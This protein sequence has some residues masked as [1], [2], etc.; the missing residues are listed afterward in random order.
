[1]NTTNTT[2][3][4][5]L[6]IVILGA[7]NSGKS[8]LLNAITGQQTSVVSDVE[9]TT[10]DIIY[11]AIELPDIGA[12]LIID[13]PGFD[14][15]SIL[16][17]K[18]M[19]QTLLAVDKA[20]VAILICGNKSLTD[21]P[22]LS[23]EIEWF[24]KLKERKIP[25][26]TVINK[27]D[28]RTNTSELSQK[29]HELFGQE[30]LEISVSSP[31]SIEN[32]RQS[33]LKKIPE[34]YGSHSITGDLVAEGDLVMLVMPQDAQAPKGRL[35]LPQVQTIRELLDK[36]CIIVSCT[37]EKMQES[38]SV[39][40]NMPKLIIT[41]SQ[42]F[43]YVFENTPAES[44]LTSF[45]VLFA[46]YKG[47]IKCFAN[48]AKAIESLTE[49]SRVLIAEACTHAPATEDIGRVKIPNLLR[50]KVGKG[51][52]I[53]IVSGNDFPKDLGKY[54]LIIHCGACMFNRKYVLNRI[55]QAKYQNIP[56]TNYGIALAQLNGILP[57]IVY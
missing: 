24:G 35:I 36:K 43:K 44:R 17:E 25:V 46:G 6:H 31:E 2:N 4:E 14:D 32:I 56:I 45:S 3:S 11:K 9:G 1:M 48:S 20:D 18:R 33:I 52:T 15:Q 29:L 50:K 23:S 13:T 8:S 21:M 51:L 54:D 16:G 34:D 40:K 37:P 49:T 19:Q 38:L 5:R 12:S 41:D 26:I 27:I 55:E 28:I 22:D 47:D 57:K 7:T 53:D 39:L 30:A 10:T 42:A